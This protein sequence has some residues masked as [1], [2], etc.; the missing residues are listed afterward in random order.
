MAYDTAAVTD[1]FSVCMLCTS[2]H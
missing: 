2:V 1:D